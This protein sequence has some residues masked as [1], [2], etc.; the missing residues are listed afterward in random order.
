LRLREFAVSRK[1]S[2]DRSVPSV[3]AP[4]RGQDI[5]EADELVRGVLAE[6]RPRAS[7]VAVAARLLELKRLERAPDAL[8]DV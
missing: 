8:T 2:R 5:A 1:T 6:Q 3:S 7:N 4:A